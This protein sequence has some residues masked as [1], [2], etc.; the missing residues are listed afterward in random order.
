MR[1]RE[2]VQ[3]KRLEEAV[4]APPQRMWMRSPQIRWTY[5]KRRVGGK[6]MGAKVLWMLRWCLY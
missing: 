5:V 4:Q 1:R 3:K 2:R 6:E